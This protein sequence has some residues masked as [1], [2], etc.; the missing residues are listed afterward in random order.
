MSL[1]I[2]DPPEESGA[3]VAGETLLGVVVVT[4]TQSILDALML[5]VEATDDMIC[6]GRG[7]DVASASAGTDGEADAVI[8]YYASSP[9][10]DLPTEVELARKQHPASAI[11]V[12]AS[13]VDDAVVAHLNGLGATAVMCSDVSLAE[14][15]DVVRHRRPA[16]DQGSRRVREDW[17]TD[18]AVSYGITPREL[19]VLWNLADGLPPQQ[20]ALRLKV[21]LN[22]VRDHLKALRHKLGC[23]SAVE[24]LV[25][26]HRRGLLPVLDR[27]LR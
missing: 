11:A 19:D 9:G 15:F 2:F 12:V 16:R 22:T 17:A 18:V 14:M 6:V 27:P 23:A 7:S 21:S 24:L 5:A 3:A 10:M 1:D 8:I 4:R 20:I 26:S 25:T 13:F